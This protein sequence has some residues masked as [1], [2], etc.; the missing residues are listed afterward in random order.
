MLSSNLSVFIALIKYTYRNFKKV[1]W[2]K[3]Y[4]KKT[5]YFQAKLSDCMAM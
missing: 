2:N 1:K 4:M 3:N 5:H